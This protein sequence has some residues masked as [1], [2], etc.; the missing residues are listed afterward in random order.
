MPRATFFERRLETVRS[1]ARKQRKNQQQIVHIFCRES[2]ME[3]VCL[4]LLLVLALSI[5]TS[6]TVVV[7]QTPSTTKTITTDSRTFGT[8]RVLA[9]R[10]RSSTQEPGE[11]IQDIDTNVFGSHPGSVMNQYQAVSHGQLTL[12]RVGV[13]EIQVDRVT[14]YQFMMQNMTSQIKLFFG[15]QPLREIADRILYCMPDGA[16]DDGTWGLAALP[17][18]FSLYH[19]SGCS[20]LGLV[21]HELGTYRV[22]WCAPS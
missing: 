13:I 5:A 3:L 14:N 17:G 4:S 2:K 1:H 20:D 21:M 9:V 8:H 19:K 18:R 6:R 16:L 12:Q 11:S 10:V 15:N 7:A 22:Y